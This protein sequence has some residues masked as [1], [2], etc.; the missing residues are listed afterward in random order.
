M[1]KKLSNNSTQVTFPHGLIV[2]YSYDTPVAIRHHASGKE[3]KTSKRW[4]RTTSK[5]INAWCNP[6]AREIP[7]GA[8]EE[9]ICK[10]ISSLKESND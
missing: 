7:Q 5:H 10:G 3:Y 1:I 6:S 4:S 8:L 2:L 9:I